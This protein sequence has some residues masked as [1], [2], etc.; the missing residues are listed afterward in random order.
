MG[1]ILDDVGPFAIE[2]RRESF[3]I[4]S[5]ENGHP[6]YLLGDLSM[7]IE[8]LEGLRAWLLANVPAAR[9]G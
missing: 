7:L 8:A 5:D 9:A 1:L 3:I 6:E 2:V 4:H